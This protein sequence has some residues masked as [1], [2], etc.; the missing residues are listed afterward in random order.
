[1][2]LECYQRGLL[3]LLKE[4]GIGCEDYLRGV[5]GTREIAVV[6]EIAVWWRVFQLEAQC[7]FTARLLKRR[8]CFQE[9]VA[10]HFNNNFTS[11]F[12]EELSRGFVLS[13]RFH[14][15]PLIASVAQ[16]EYAWLEVRDCSARVF[17][18]LW[19]RHPDLVFHALDNGS[20]LP[21]PETGCFYCMEV[22]QD[23]PGMIA[24]KRH[25]YAPD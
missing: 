8:G 3:D 21:E 7:P 18:V 4:R 19:D 25:T 5:A 6:R 16:F 24:C 20:N 22:A 17:E 23:V 1:M 12:V 13:L 15:D 11:P 10:S 2:D 9:L 14:D